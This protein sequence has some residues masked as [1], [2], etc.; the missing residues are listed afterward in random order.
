MRHNPGHRPLPQPTDIIAINQEQL[1]LLWCRILAKSND[2]PIGETVLGLSP[3]G[4]SRLSEPRPLNL[5]RRVQFGSIE[6][7]LVKPQSQ[8]MF[9]ERNPDFCQ[10]LSG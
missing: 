9:Q 6:V 3:L 7:G 5:M 10:L 8:S 4:P 1:Q 2:P